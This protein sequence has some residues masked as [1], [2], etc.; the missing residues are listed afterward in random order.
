MFVYAVNYSSSKENRNQQ[1][2]LLAGHLQKNRKSESP[3]EIAI[4]AS[5]QISIQFY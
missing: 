5:L 1:K 4:S 3:M 2:S